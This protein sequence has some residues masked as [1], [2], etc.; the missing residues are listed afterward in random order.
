MGLLSRALRQAGGGFGGKYGAMARTL[1]R[2]ASR[3]YK[4]DVARAADAIMPD[5]SRNAG[6]RTGV[7]VGSV[8]GGLA[9]MGLLANQSV[10][11]RHLSSGNPE[12]L[13][14]LD[15]IDAV[16]ARER[17][18]RREIERISGAQ[19]PYMPAIEQAEQD[20]RGL[21]AY[22]RSLPGQAPPLEKLQYMLMPDST[23]RSG[24]LDSAHDPYADA[25]LT[26]EERRALLQRMGRGGPR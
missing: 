15:E 4:P 25:G 18:L 16:R 24:G 20:W 5:G 12:E 21:Q 10:D 13:A 22:D 3:A 14:L 2:P 19:S 1:N 6:W 11:P 8:S 17:E 26:P 9:G 7:S 23:T